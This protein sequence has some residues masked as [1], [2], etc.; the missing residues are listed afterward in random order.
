MWALAILT[1]CSCAQPGTRR[2]CEDCELKGKVTST[3]VPVA[4]T[5]HVGFT[6]VE[7]CYETKGRQTHLLISVQDFIVPAPDG[8]VDSREPSFPHVEFLPTCV[9]LAKGGDKL[10]KHLNGAFSTLSSAFSRL[11]LPERDTQRRSQEWLFLWKKSY[12][13]S[14]TSWNAVFR[15]F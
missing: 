10:F 14:S 2:G 1:C 15:T 6:K 5:W 13:L 12:Y 11:I 7:G 9:I 3:P 4:A 8:S